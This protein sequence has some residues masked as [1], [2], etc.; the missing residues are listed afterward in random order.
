LTDV[1]RRFIRKV[2]VK[3]LGSYLCIKKLVIG[4]I[5]VLLIVGFSGCVEKGENILLNS[6]FEEGSNG[7]PLYW[8][9]AIVPADNLTML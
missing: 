6:D 4:I 8:F 7:E 9:Q 2:L 3:I 1:I 5:F